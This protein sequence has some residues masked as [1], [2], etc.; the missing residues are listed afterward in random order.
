MSDTEYDEKQQRES[1]LLEQFERECNDEINMIRAGHS[2]INNR[3]ENYK[4]KYGVDFS[5]DAKDI[6]GDSE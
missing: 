4:S 2:I 3:V 1:E 6:I 5:S